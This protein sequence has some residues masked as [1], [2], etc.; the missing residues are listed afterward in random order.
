MP[1]DA[2]SVENKVK[3]GSATAVDKQ[4]N[5]EKG[6][7]FR[8]QG[9]AARAGMS[10][11]EKAREG[12]KRDKVSFICALGNPAKKQMRVQD[13]ENI[14]SFEV[15]GYKFNLAEPM[16]VPN[17]PLKEKFKD[18]TDCEPATE[19]QAP[20]GEVFLNIVETGIFIS[21]L[22]FAGQFTGG[23]K[24]VSLQ[25]KVSGNREH[26]MPVLHL[27]NSAGS[28]KVGMELVGQVAST[29]DKGK[30][31]SYKA[32]P[33]YEEKFGKLFM[34]RRVQKGATPDKKKGETTA[35]IAAAFRQLYANKQ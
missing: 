3:G 24:P 2:N 4:A 29:D 27:N 14:D 9:E 7:A 6:I 33:Q 22:E 20:A 17:A 10:E 18:L 34:K 15:V 13:K 35:D 12:E 32:F 19:V 1:F 21:R 28:I 8:K 31:T 11:D 25:A 5:K 23:D 16:M 30:A 26:P